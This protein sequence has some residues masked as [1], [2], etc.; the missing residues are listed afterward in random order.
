MR[1]IRIHEQGGPEVLV[2]E[3]IDDPSS[4]GDG[5]VVVRL[6]VAGVN[7]IDVQQR[8]GAYGVE[9]PYTPGTEGAGEVAAVGSSVDGFEPGDRVAFAGLTGA[10]AELV[11]APADRL[12]P[13]PTDVPTEIAAAVLLQGMTAHYLIG[14]VAPLEPGDLVVV[15]AAA[16]G[17]G[18]LLTQLAARRGLRVIGSTSTEEKAPLAREA[19][20]SDVVIRGRDD[21]P[22]LV[23]ERTGGAGARA[24]FDSVGRDTFEDSLAS[25]A[26]R[27]FLVVFGQSSGAVPPFDLRRLQQ[28][29]SVFLTRPG[30]ADYTVGDDLAMRAKEV[31]SLV[32]A[33]SLHVTI[34]ARYP[35][36]R[37]ADAHRELGS[38]TS[39]GKLVLLTRA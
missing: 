32:A 31:F 10:Y 7:M 28:A 29:G 4:P 18:L 13:V 24:V 21:L 1:A 25:L 39:A 19:G 22:A 33:G 6:D 35:L 37:A 9:V 11:V 14:S 3:E 23:R 34:H 12:V 17:V 20:A 36:G 38:G 27:A 26:R 30:L 15:H 8:S 2:L 16:G 5:E